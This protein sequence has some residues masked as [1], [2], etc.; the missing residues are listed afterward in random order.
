MKLV[1]LSLF[2]ILQLVAKT[3]FQIVNSD[4]ARRLK[5]GPEALFPEF[6][7]LKTGEIT[8]EV[9]I[10]RVSNL[11]LRLN[12]IKE[13]HLRNLGHLTEYLFYHKAHNQSSNAQMS[14]EENTEE[15][16]KSA[17]QKEE[18][19]LEKSENQKENL[20]S[21]S[22][23]NR[24]LTHLIRK[25]I[26]SEEKKLSNKHQKNQKLHEFGKINSQDSDFQKMKVPNSPQNEINIQHLSKEQREN[27]SPELQQKHS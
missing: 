7:E 8:L 3:P 23:K 9:A 22:K 10:K 20:K 13:K 14:H 19:S 16:T 25:L 26:R 17:V 15:I 27:H 4:S 21:S 5:D 6:S 1:V 2:I 12:K 24:K 11:L 18:V